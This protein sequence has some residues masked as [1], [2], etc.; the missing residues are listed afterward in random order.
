MTTDKDFPLKDYLA[1]RK[2]M[3][4]EALNHCLPG[5]EDFP[6]MIKRMIKLTPKTRCYSA[7]RNLGFRNY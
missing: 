4:D 2:E 3:I 6:P 5:P 7:L 1:A